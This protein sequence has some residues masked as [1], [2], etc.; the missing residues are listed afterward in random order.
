MRTNEFLKTDYANA[1]QEHQCINYC[2]EQAKE[3]LVEGEIEEVHLLM[4]DIEKSV[5]TIQKMRLRK[6]EMDNIHLLLKRLQ[7]LGIDVVLVERKLG[8]F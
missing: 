7:E 5:I 2:L 3:R 1:L 8:G 4:K 6:K